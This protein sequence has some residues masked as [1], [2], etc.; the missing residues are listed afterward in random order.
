MPAPCW[1]DHPLFVHANGLT[2]VLVPLAPGSFDLDTSALSLAMTP[3]TCAVLLSHPA[4][5][6][7]RLYGTD[8][9][10][11]LE[12]VISRAER[13]FDV[14]I[15]MIADETHRDFVDINGY[16]SV[17]AHR[18]RTLI[19]YSFGKYHF[20]QGQRI[21]YVAVSPRHPGRDDVADEMVRW[22]RVLGFATP[23]A[24]MQRAL[25]EL[26]RLASRPDLARRAGA[27]ATSTSS[28]RAG[29]D[30]VRPDATLF[31]Y[32]RTPPGTE[33]FEFVER[34]ARA[35]VLVLPAPVFHHEGYFR[36]SLTG[37]EDMLE[38]ALPILAGAA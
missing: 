18:D 13:E 32:V 33:D 5:P 35:G 34:L 16:R 1:L 15:T 10:A 7:G 8:E 11:R 24:L 17:A 9:L 25:P 31:M 21:G 38:R 23:T 2:P 4:N 22:T 28:R 12:D 6:T 29:Y 3:R 30:V 26:L 37:S 27:S 20:M 36:L 14:S 19:V